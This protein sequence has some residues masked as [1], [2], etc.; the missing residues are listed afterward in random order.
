MVEL[1]LLFMTVQLNT[2]LR[3]VSSGLKAFYGKKA[4][5]RNEITKRQQ[6]NFVQ[7]EDERQVG[8]R[9]VFALSA[10]G[11]VDSLSK[12]VTQQQMC[13]EPDQGSAKS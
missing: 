4:Q 5:L 6:E 12:P 2:V 8:T 11:P 10:C 13:V 7:A 1:L 9:R 3:C